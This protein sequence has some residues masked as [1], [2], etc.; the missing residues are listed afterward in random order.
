MRK[1]VLI[2]CTGNS[3]R[4][5]MAEGFLKSIAPDLE[6]HSAGTHPA[7]EVHPTAVRVM[8]EAG[9]DISG[10]HPKIVGRFLDQNFDYVITVCDGARETCPVFPGKVHY[11][12]HFPFPDPAMAAGTEEEVLAEFR[13][14]RDKIKDRFLRFYNEERRKI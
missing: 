12:L 4:S 8:Q 7:K 2:L 11:K 3:C 5:Q 10:H 9:V 1:K 14:V 6:V 13:G